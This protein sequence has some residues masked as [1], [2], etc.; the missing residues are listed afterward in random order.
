MPDGGAGTGQGPVDGGVT[1]P[2]AGVILFGGAGPWPLTNVSYTAA[3]GI[4]ETPVVGTSTDETQNLWVATHDALYLLQPGQ[5]KFRR[6]DASAGLHLATNPVTYCDT[7]GDKACPIQGAAAARGIS[8]IVGGGSQEVFVGF[9]GVDE[10]ASL[11]GGILFPDWT[12]PDRHTGKMDRVRLTADGTLQVDRFDFVSGVSNEFWHDRTVDR[13]VFDHFIHKHDL[14][15][16]TNHGVTFLRPDRFRY[17]NPGERFDFVNLE[18]MADHLHPRVCYHSACG[19]T[20]RDN[21]RMGDWRGLAFDGTGQLWV[22]GRWTAGLIAQDPRLDPNGTPDMMDWITRPGEAAYP[23]AF[24]DP[25]DAATTPVGSPAQPVFRPPQEGDPVDLSAVAVLPDG[26]VWFASGPYYSGVD[27]V[28]YGVA[29][30]DGS[31][32]TPFDPQA[33]LGMG[34]RNVRDIIALPDGRLVFAGPNTGLV[35]YNP[36]NGS[37]VPL[38]AGGGIPDNAVNRLELDM[39]VNPPALH[40]STNTGASVIRMLPSN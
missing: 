13:L 5:V 8:E 33:N 40:V 4:L 2:D 1:A 30:F 3:D 9:Y 25:Y 7:F 15:V 6:F 10:T 37:H 16:G 28:A 18:W 32:F 35:I 14:Y 22:A 21:Q 12:D 27:D 36:A 24:G 20:E 11:D 34:E 29:M 17:P 38:T 39:M 31:A 23:K 19:G 26:K